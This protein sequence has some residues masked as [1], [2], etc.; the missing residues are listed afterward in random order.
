MTQFP[1]QTGLVGAP[2]VAS[3]FIQSSQSMATAGYFIFNHRYVDSI[4]PATID[5]KDIKFG[6]DCFFVHKSDSVRGVFMIM[7]FSDYCAV[8]VAG[9]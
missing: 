2:Y 3:P 5:G 7:Y 8:V 1:V 4:E 9:K 6:Q